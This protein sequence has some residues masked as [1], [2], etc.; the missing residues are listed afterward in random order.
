MHSIALARFVHSQFNNVIKLANKYNYN[1]WKSIYCSPRTKLFGKT[2]KSYTGYNHCGLMSYFLAYHLQKQYPNKK[3][4]VG[5]ARHNTINDNH[6]CILHDDIIIDPTYRQ[7]FVPPVINGTTKKE[8]YL[9]E[10][11]SPFFV[12]TKDE[13]HNIAKHMNEDWNN[14]GQWWNFTDTKNIEFDLY[15]IVHRHK[16]N[17][18][19]ENMQL[20]IHYLKSL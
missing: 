6:V 9:F 4:T 2:S 10:T 19:D 7:F 13:L 1:V 12:G 3:F 20:I 16:I 14:A 11:L 5:Y 8:K 15:D 18:H 17:Y